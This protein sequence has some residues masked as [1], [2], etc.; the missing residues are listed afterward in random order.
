MRSNSKW[1]RHEHIF[2]CSWC[3]FCSNSK[4]LLF[5]VWKHSK[6]RSKIKEYRLKWKRMWFGEKKQLFAGGF[7][8]HFPA[9]GQF[10]RL[11]LVVIIFTQFLFFTIVVFKTASD[12]VWFR[13]FFFHFFRW[14]AA[15]KEAADREFF[16]RPWATHYL[17]RALALRC[18][19]ASWVVGSW[20]VTTGV[21]ALCGHCV[22]PTS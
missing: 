11:S 9:G 12:V 7:F 19:G 14:N 8:Y 3:F 2:S 17:Q 6:K 1:G 10:L 15:K 20:G 21:C 4:H 18:G 22:E 16:T 13:V 5:P